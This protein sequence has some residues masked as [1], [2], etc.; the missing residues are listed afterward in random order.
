MILIFDIKTGEATIFNADNA[1][2]SYLNINYRS[3]RS[4]LKPGSQ[5][6]NGYIV[7]NLINIIKRRK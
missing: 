5:I 6:I 1:A 7:T 3:L 2:S 4:K